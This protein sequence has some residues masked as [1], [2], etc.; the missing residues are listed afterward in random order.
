MSCFVLTRSFDG[1]KTTAD[2]LGKNG[3]DFVE[4][5]AV[6]MW[7]KSEHEAEIYLDTSSHWFKANNPSL[8]V[9]SYDPVETLVN[10]TK[11]DRATM[12]QDALRGMLRE[13]N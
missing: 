4:S 11:T 9:K 7:F 2:Y 8:F 3:Y 10:P 5:G 6:A 1:G 13:R 12:I